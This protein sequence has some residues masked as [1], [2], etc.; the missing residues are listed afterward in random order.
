VISPRE[1]P[2]SSGK[3]VERKC[4]TEELIAQ[5]WRTS[6]RVQDIYKSYPNP[7]KPLELGARVKI[8]VDNPTFLFPSLEVGRTK[9][10]DSG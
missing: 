6:V 4:E 7:V 10:D 1:I 5:G 3:L 9:G 8:K 2:R